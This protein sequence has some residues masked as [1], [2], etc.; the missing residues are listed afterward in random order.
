MSSDADEL[1]SLYSDKTF[2]SYRKIFFFSRD[3][4]FLQEEKGYFFKETNLAARKKM[5]RQENKSCYSRKYFLGIINQFCL[6]GA[7]F[8]RAS[9]QQYFWLH[10]LLLIY[11]KK[12]L[13]LPIL[14][15]LSFNVRRS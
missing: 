12:S 13:I 14:P 8:V 5:L 7:T 1:F 10:P 4:I 2:F 3:F 11:T 6:L 15:P 9:T